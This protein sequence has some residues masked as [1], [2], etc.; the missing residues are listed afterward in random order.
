[1]TDTVIHYYETLG[2]EPG[3]DAAA[4]KKAYFRLIRLHPPEKDPE[5]FQELRRAYE[6]LKDGSPVEEKY[7]EDFPLTDNPSVL[8]LLK[9]AGKLFDQGNEK[10]AADCFIEALN[11]L[12]G[13]PFLLLNLARLQR[14]AGNPRKA[15]RT[16][17]QLQQVAPDYAEAYALAATGYYEGGW[18]KKAFPEFKKALALGYDERSFR[19]DYADA[20][21]KNGEHE[22]A[23]AQRA[24]LLNGTKWD[25]DNTVEALYL[26][27]AQMQN[28]VTGAEALPVLEEYERF[29]TRNRRILRGYGLELLAPF[30]A[31]ATDNPALP[32]FHP[33]YKKADEL[34]VMIA[35]QADGLDEEQ[36]L[37]VRA[38][39]L[40]AALK[41]DTAFS[42]EWKA[43]IVAAIASTPLD[44]RL[45]RFELLDPLLCLLMERERNLPQLQVIRR[46][47]P[48]GYEFIRPYGELFTQ[49]KANGQLEKLKKEYARLSEQYEGGDFYLCYPE[50]KPHPRGVVSYNGDTPF[51]RAA[52]KPGRND[53][54]PCGSGLKFKRCCQ[55]KGIYD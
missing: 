16:A 55:G 44:S 48:F 45:E 49:S 50:E 26:F 52:K 38:N 28:S 39:L 29:L 31:A 6:A 22:T 27:G 3:A 36:L 4:V 46:D 2:L 51:V 34:T 53:P 30:M 10:A 1:M 32:R 25:R 12:P 17:K 21:D 54:C 43:F 14:R 41:Q 40:M 42:R 15:A 20:A 5:Q 9:H 33:F 37:D 8:Y 24:A 47:Y 7:N 13:D 23:F 11:I 18:Y 19:I 35:G